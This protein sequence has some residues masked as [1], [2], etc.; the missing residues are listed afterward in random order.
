MRLNATQKQVLLT[1]KNTEFQ[2]LRFFNQLENKGDIAL[3][4]NKSYNVAQLFNTAVLSDSDFRYAAFGFATLGKAHAVFK[5]YNGLYIPNEKILTECEENLI[6][7][8][9]AHQALTKLTLAG[10]FP[11]DMDMELD[12]AFDLM[13]EFDPDLNEVDAVTAMS[14]LDLVAR[15]D[16]SV[17][18]RKLFARSCKLIREDTAEIA[19]AGKHESYGG[20]SFRE[21]WK[22]GIKKVFASDYSI[23]AIADY[24]GLRDIHNRN[25]HTWSDMSCIVMVQI[26]SFKGCSLLGFSTFN[27]RIIIKTAP[28][29]MGEV[30]V[31][32]SA[33]VVPNEVQLS[34][35]LLKDH[36]KDPFLTKMQVSDQFQSIGFGLDKEQVIEVGLW[37]ADLH[38]AI[39]DPVD[40]EGAFDGQRLAFVQYRHYVPNI[41]L[42]DKKQLTFYTVAQYP[43]DEHL[44]FAGESVAEMCG[45]GQIRTLKSLH[46]LDSPNF[47][48]QIVV[49]DEASPELTVMT[50][51]TDAQAPAGLITIGGTPL[52]HLPVNWSDFR[53]FVV[54]GQPKGSYEDGQQATILLDKVYKGKHAFETMPVDL[55]ELP[56]LGLGTKA[57]L[58]DA[59]VAQ[60]EKN[61]A[62]PH[63]GYALVRQEALQ[64]ATVIEGASIPPLLSCI[65]PDRIQNDH[66]LLQVE[67]FARGFKNPLE[68]YVFHI[69]GSVIPFAQDCRKRNASVS[70]RAYGG[71]IDEDNPHISG[72]PRQD[73]PM[74]GYTGAFAY[75]NGVFKDSEE[76]WGEQI[77]RAYCAIFTRLQNLGYSNVEF[78]IPNISSPL[79]LELLG[80][81]MAEYGLF[82][83]RNK[84][85]NKPFV[86]KVMLETAAAFI[87]AGEFQQMGVDKF[88]GGLNDT[89]QGVDFYDR[90]LKQAYKIR[91]NLETK[92]YYV[93]H[94]IMFEAIKN[95]PA[96]Y[97]TCGVPS[98][99]FME[100]LVTK[101][102]YAIGLAPG[103]A[104]VEGYQKIYDTKVKLGLIK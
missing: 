6:T 18:K 54:G 104:F 67:R 28:G 103:K 76:N 50:N 70:L 34:I 2:Y 55:N 79:E 3:V 88:S 102:A 75:I 37:I 15:N 49:F 1:V 62:L 47:A 21:Q 66:L 26:D 30:L 73:N 22:L 44:L 84:R 52:S 33:S 39:G 101:G 4:G 38:D 89:R 23:Q 81:I 95:T 12:L 86:L 24:E 61:S 51:L 92:P 25:L 48:G 36:T 69:T 78:F 98:L 13:V 97:E 7:R 46:E 93:L 45:E 58:V 53:P 85:H 17:A 71:R 14:E 32:G 87:Y 65:Y 96:T 40:T 91:G 77:F 99:G 11:P 31:G 72:L 35:S 57:K 90:G 68:A 16:I 19:G 29:M 20:L 80:T 82:L 27:D 41:V 10:N 43:D 56:D 9:E 60:V 59:R 100:Y 63:S 94:D 64:Q 8:N 83:H 5:S 42:R 74:I